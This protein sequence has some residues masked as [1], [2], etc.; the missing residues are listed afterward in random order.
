[1]TS[2][3]DSAAAAYIPK[4]RATE[5]E[6]LSTLQEKARELGYQ[7]VPVEHEREG[8]P[9]AHP[10]T[11]SAMVRR[12][13]W[14]KS[15]KESA[16]AQAKSYEAEYAA[17][18]AVSEEQMAEEGIDRTTVDGWT[19]FFHPTYKLVKADEDATSEDIQD[20]LMASG[21]ASMIKQGYSYQSLQAYF[22]ELHEG[23]MSVPERLAKI[24]RLE[25]SQ[26]LRLR[27][28]GKR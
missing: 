11:V 5:N 28:A 27:R 2:V 23:G 7:L 17:L 4:A 8:A 9:E 24:F 26:E 16:E 20:A 10:E 25:S 12:L 14:L 21:L 15:A 19:A 13:A 3:I 18:R 22:K 6:E 1:M